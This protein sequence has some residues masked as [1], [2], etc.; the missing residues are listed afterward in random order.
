MRHNGH[1]KRP[2]RNYVASTFVGKC[3]TI[4]P[5]PRMRRQREDG[6]VKHI[7]CPRCGKKHPFKEYGYR[8]SWKTLDGEV[9]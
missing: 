4:I 7:W 1:G 8:N 5:L 2:D 3:G 6:H 9:V